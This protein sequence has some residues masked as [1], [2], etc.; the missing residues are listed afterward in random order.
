MIGIRIDAPAARPRG[1]AGVFL[2]IA[3]FDP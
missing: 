1:G 2:G 3:A